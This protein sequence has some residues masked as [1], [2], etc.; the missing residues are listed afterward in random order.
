MIVDP[1]FCSWDTTSFLLIFSDNVSE[2]FVYY[3]HIFPALSILIFVAVLLKQDFSNKL[4]KILSVIALALVGWCFSDLVLWADANPDHIMFFWSILIYFELL[5]YIGSLY[6]IHYFISKKM[7][8]WRIESLILFLCIPIFLFAHTKLNLAAFDYTNC[9]KEAVEGPLVLYAYILE[10]IISVSIL[11]YALW[12]YF[13]CTDKKVRRE[14]A[15]AST[16]ILF[17]LFAFSFGNI[18]GTLEVDYELG[19]FGLFATPIF[20]GILAYMSIRYKT[21]NLKA[22]SAEILVV[23]IILLIV[24]ILFNTKIEN[25]RIIAGLTAIATSALGYMLIKSVKKEVKQREEIEKLAINLKDANERLKALDKMKSE[26]V[27]IAS[28]QLRSPLT[29]IRGYAS[30]LIEGSY[31]KLAG[32]SQEVV[33]RIAESAKY[34]ALSVEDYLN[35]SRIEAGNMKYEMG[36]FNLKEV[37]EKVVDELRPVAIKKGL[38]MVFRSDC[39][40]SCS[41]RADI[42]KTRQVLM[43]IIDNSMKYTPKGSITVVVHDDPKQK[44]VSV[45]VSDTGV[46]MSKQTQEEVFEKFVRAKNA[47]NV[48]V[49]GTGLGLYV[50]KKMI[51]DMGGKVWSESEGE[52]KGPTFHI[53]LPLIPGNTPKR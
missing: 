7:L 43:N 44:M 21:F 53:E 32:K 8:D 40:G 17:F 2:N 9:L 29:S 4:V 13:K 46:G 5:V 45:T 35:V 11:L 18:I 31:G 12:S 42:G 34:M 14:I 47:N 27:S 15:L 26:F 41:T 16:G 22:I 6:F 1:A 39:D 19:Q 51:V 49:T 23:T 28:H 52:G 10:I 3:S 37:T 24:S 38:V 50:A 30:M 25:V 33:E 48:N 36:D 20:I